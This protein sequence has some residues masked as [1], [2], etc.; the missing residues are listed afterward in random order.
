MENYDYE[1]LAKGA[2][3]EVENADQAEASGPAIPF[4]FTTSQGLREELGLREDL[5]INPAKRL[6]PQKTA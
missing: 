3:T 6:K 5:I 4:T 1:E 2:P